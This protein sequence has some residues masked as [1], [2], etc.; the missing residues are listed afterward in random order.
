LTATIPA[1]FLAV[2]GNVQISVTDTASHTGKQTLLVAT[3]P[4]PSASLAPGTLSFAEQIV[5][6]S[7]AP[8]Q[9]T[10]SNKGTAALLISGVAAGAD[11]SETNN[12]STVAAGSS[13]SILVV[14]TPSAAGARSGTLTITD[15]DPSGSQSVALSG[16]AS[17][18]QIGGA[19][20][21]SPTAT[22]KAGS[23]A[24]Y[25]VSITPQGGFAG[26]VTFACSNLPQYASCT[27]NPPSAALT[28]SALTVTVTIATTQQQSASVV[29]AARALFASFAG[30]GILLVI[31][32]AASPRKA[33][34]FA[35]RCLPGLFFLLVLTFFTIAGCGGGGAAPSVTPSAAHTTAAGTYTVNFIVTSSGISRSTPLT[36]VVQ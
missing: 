8:Q 10:V 12:C 18:L 35:V 3:L 34:R 20:S 36:L 6:T 25:S 7:S 15:N 5:G 11:F 13:C 31:G 30:F 26:P 29:T 16:T 28:G 9:V 19:G 27:F 14:F 22:V 33:E 24:N 1:S 21:S 17:D 32:S 23:P 2:A 4:T